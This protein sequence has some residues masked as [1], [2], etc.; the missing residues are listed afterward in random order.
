MS[1]Q[2]EPRPRR[3][4]WRTITGWLALAL[5]VVVAAITVT[6]AWN[7]W[8]LVELHRTLGDP[9]PGAFLTLLLVLAGDLLLAPVYSE[10]AYQ[11]RMR[12]RVAL[13]LLTVAS[14]LVLVVFNQV[15]LFR[16]DTR[17]VARSADGT[18]TVA[19]VTDMNG[20]QLHAFTGTGWGQR[21]LGSLGHACGTSVQVRFASATEVVVDTVYGSFHL[22]LDPGTGAPRDRLSADCAGG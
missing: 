20:D 10:A 8:S 19:V 9:A 21:D 7:P 11:G 5:A 6:G 14:L 13:V 2:S 22:H 12:L 16:Y 4:R 15:Q 18:R 17:T 3:A 1:E